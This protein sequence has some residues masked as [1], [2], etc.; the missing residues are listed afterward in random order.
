MLK[1]FTSFPNQLTGCDLILGDCALLMNS[2][3]D[4][5][6]DLTVTSPP[7]DGLRTYNGY[8]FDFENIARQL[9][10]VTKPGG[11]LYLGSW[12]RNYWRM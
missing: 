5:L 11:G 1:T 9:Y 4:D 6:V 2:F 12:R 8:S 3:P 7:Y 10:R